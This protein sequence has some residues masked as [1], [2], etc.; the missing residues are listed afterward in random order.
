M[1]VVYGVTVVSP[2]DTSTSDR[3][4]KNEKYL[5]QGESKSV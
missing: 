2:T 4:L 3:R 5:E 1:V